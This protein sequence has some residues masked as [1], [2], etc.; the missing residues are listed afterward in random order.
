MCHSEVA[1]ATAERFG[2]SARSMLRKIIIT[3]LTLTAVPFLL[4]S[5]M[6]LP[7]R[8]P[9]IAW[10]TPA[11]LLIATIAVALLLRLC[12]KTWAE[13]RPC[14]T[15]SWKRVV[16]IM[17][18]LVLMTLAM[19]VPDQYPWGRDWTWRTPGEP[20]SST[21]LVLKRRLYIVARTSE[22]ASPASGEWVY[23]AHVL[24]WGG[25]EC[26]YVTGAIP[27]YDENGKLSAQPPSALAQ[28]T[29]SV[30]STMP[31]ALLAAYPAWALSLSTRRAWRR[32]RRWKR[33]LALR[34]G[35]TGRCRECG[36]NLTGNVSGRCPECGRRS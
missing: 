11:A 16:F 23:P 28:W 12:I 24:T 8:W 10:D 20:M 9:R 5:A 26:R 34:G 2:D 36:Y 25:F 29:L 1:P 14:R 31:V 30:P 3:F 4:G 19:Q 18:L 22:I 6:A 21:R 35:N 27:H 17:L 32:R 13:R 15:R 33:W 7:R